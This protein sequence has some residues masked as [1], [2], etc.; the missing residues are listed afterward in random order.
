MAAACKDFNASGAALVPP[1]QFDATASAREH[2][3]Q[4]TPPPAAQLIGTPLHLANC[5]AA[6][7]LARAG[8]DHGAP[9]P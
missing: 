3:R 5:T 1:V 4:P 8:G 6:E 2:L 7:P 9:K